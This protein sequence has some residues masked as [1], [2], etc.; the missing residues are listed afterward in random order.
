MTVSIYTCVSVIYTL[1]EIQY[2]MEPT[3][4]V[5]G[6]SPF[7]VKV[8]GTVEMFNLKRNLLQQGCSV[9]LKMVPHF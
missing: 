8:N 7:Y 3:S 2:S 6:G 9:L 5:V 1:K 4:H